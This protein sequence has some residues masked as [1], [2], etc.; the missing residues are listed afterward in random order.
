VPNLRD[1]LK[2]IREL[3]KSEA[4]EEPQ[5]RS[6]V[7]DVSIEGW[8][9]C[10]FQVL[11][12]DVEVDAPLKKLKKLPAALTV[13]VPDL[14][15]R[16][17]PAPEDF[18][19]FDLETSGLSGGAGTVAFLAAFGRVVT[20]GKLRVTQYLLLDYPGESDFIDAV[21]KE[22][23]DESSVI[24]SYNGKCFDSQ[25]LKTR[26][27]MNGIK[28]PVYSHADL[29]HPARR[30]WKNIIGDC[31]QS[32]V[33]THI[34]GLD[35]TGDIPGSLA[36]DIWFDFLKTGST[37]RLLGICDH[38]LADIAGLS[39]MLAAMI[40]IAANP[41]NAK[42]RYDIERLALY[43]HNL[44]RRR[45]KHLQL[46]QEKSANA[47]F[48]ELKQTGEK[49]LL[50][51]AEKDHP[52][53]SLVYASFLL[54]NANYEEARNRLQK[55][56]ASDFPA[57]IKAAALRTMAIDTERRLKRCED[58][59]IFVNRG[60]ELENTNA[61]WQTEFKKRKERLEKKV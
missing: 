61:F 26:C 1:R 4:A 21:L 51:A 25:V 52:R 57:Q 32:S 53:A 14:A 41:F 3:K 48:I 34:L 37:E 35:R 8:E 33:E 19:F 45:V 20:G 43:W 31:S 11:K 39:A 6:L 18:L 12:R 49:L 15:G 60:L 7:V 56:A 27:L 40:G 36:P 47:Q 17:L 58:A 50:F 24:V 55:I 42:Y 38:N 54:K 30:L 2:T 28:P 13:L 22:F 16:E 5:T 29:L 9:T 23:N 44:L 59:L 46:T 10:G